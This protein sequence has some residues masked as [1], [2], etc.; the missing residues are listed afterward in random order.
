MKNL[1]F[2]LPLIA[3]AAAP[4]FA[5]EDAKEFAAEAEF[6]AI[7]TSGNTDSTAI[8]G[9]I[10]IKQEL[11][12]WRTHYIAKA[13]YKE[14]EVDIITDGVE[15][16]D[17]QTTAEKYFLS[18]QGDYK[19]NEEHRGLFAFG[20]YEE[21]KFSGYE[22]QATIAA[23]YSDRLFKTDNS[24]LNYSIGPGYSFYENEDTIDETDTVIPGESEDSLIIRLFLDYSYKFS[25]NA[26]FTQTV[27]T[28][29]ATDSDKNTK[30]RA[31]SA[32][33]AKINTSFALRASFTV[34]NNSE[35]ADDKENTDTQTAVTLVYSF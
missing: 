32:I 20:S 25:E 27:S 33:T 3:A 31:E 16:T 26:K 23:G 35:V 21:D 30:T 8:A 10:D 24:F 17:E 2:A 14:D 19:L 5:E 11:T 13:L 12:S 1:R 7:I 28:D 22:Y 6:G 9:K 29:Y 34:T 18:A 4:C 15:T